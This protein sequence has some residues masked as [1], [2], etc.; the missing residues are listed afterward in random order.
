VRV[1]RVI[2]FLVLVILVVTLQAQAFEQ[3]PPP[4]RRDPS[5]LLIVDGLL[6]IA[7][8]LT[9]LI[10]ELGH[11]IAGAA[12]RLRIVGF[13]IALLRAGSHVKFALPANAT[14]LPA[15]MVTAILAGPAA[16]L[17][18][19]AAAFGYDQRQKNPFVHLGLI[20]AC[21]VW[22][23][24]GLA[25]LVPFRSR[26]GPSD[27][28]RVAQWIGGPTRRRQALAL[29]AEATATLQRAATINSGAED[30][31]LHTIIDTD[32]D[33]A[34]VLLAAARRWKRDNSVPTPEMVHDGRRLAAIVRDPHTPTPLAA[35]AATF[36]AALLGN[37]YLRSTIVRKESVQQSTV[38]ELAGLA[39]LGMHHNPDTA[40]SRVALAM[41]RLLQHRPADA[42]LLLVGYPGADAGSYIKQA[43]PA[44]RAI[45]EAYLDDLD[46][47]KRLY[48]VA[49][50]AGCDDDDL[51]LITAAMG[52][53]EI[54]VRQSEPAGPSS[55]STGKGNGGAEQAAAGESHR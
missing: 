51:S 10:H 13:R 42:R 12:L 45:A 9:P 3:L 19:A 54:V 37:A 33:P 5:G 1:S 44:T 34:L 28:L 8:L 6:L 29:R 53:P 27:G 50:E 24:A 2:N 22:T 17:L 11:A 43:V 52:R 30:A 36:V 35:V 39:E 38:D 20:G 14:A 18:T 16:N 40:E 26:R 23:Y 47:A 4:S 49:A 41:I 32:S 21:V 48:R 31:R 15:R 55:T 25:N 46:Q 7:L